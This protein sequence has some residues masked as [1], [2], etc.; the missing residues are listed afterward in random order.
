ML[1]HT[2]LPGSFPFHFHEQLRPGSLKKGHRTDVVV[3]SSGR[4][5]MSNEG[6]GA[7]LCDLRINII[8]AIRNHF[9]ILF[10]ETF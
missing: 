10:L 8:S 7:F 6:Y 9:I 5:G 2:E 4:D 3:K 1:F